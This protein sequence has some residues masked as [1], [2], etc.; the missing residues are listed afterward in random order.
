VIEGADVIRRFLLIILD[1]ARMRER[2]LGD[3]TSTYAHE[4]VIQSQ[5][6]KMGLPL[7]LSKIRGELYYL[8][9][10]GLV[11]FRK[12]RVHGEDYFQ[13]RIEGG[14]VDVLAGDRHEPGIARE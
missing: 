3:D 4:F 5:L 13:W 1:A 2:G 7:S 6:Q 8:K 11:E 14:G 10:K 9:D 12:T